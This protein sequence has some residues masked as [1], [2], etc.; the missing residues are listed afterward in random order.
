M[1]IGGALRLAAASLALS[2]VA[3]GWP[4]AAQPDPLVAMNALRATPP[5]PAPDVTF[6]E[7]D[8][9]QVSLATFRGRPVLVTFFTTW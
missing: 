5:P 9:R 7:L 1:K 3:A 4:A 8:G 2:I 6:R